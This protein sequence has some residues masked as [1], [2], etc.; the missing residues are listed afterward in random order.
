[1]IDSHYVLNSN[2]LPG[3][4]EDVKRSIH[5]V[6]ELANSSKDRSGVAGLNAMFI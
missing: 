1:V 2:R 6:C 4:V 3:C 5:E